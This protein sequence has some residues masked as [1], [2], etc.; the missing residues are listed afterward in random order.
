MRYGWSSVDAKSLWDIWCDP[1]IVSPVQRKTLDGAEPFDE[2]EEFILFASHYFLLIACTSSSMVSKGGAACLIDDAGDGVPNSTLKGVLYSGIRPC[3]LPPGL[4]IQRF[5]SAFYS[6]GV[7]GIHGGL[8]RQG[9]SNT[10][11]LFSV[12]TPSS[13]K[14]TAGC[15]IVS[16]DSGLIL[17][18]AIESRMC[19]AI[20]TSR[21]GTCLLIG[22]RVSP[23]RP[24]MDCWYFNGKWRQV[25]DLPVPLYRQCATWIESAPGIST[26]LAVLVF[27]GKTISN[28]VSG[29]WLLWRDSIGWST[30]ECKGDPIPPTFGATMASIDM[31]SG[32]LIG[33]MTA[34]SILQPNVWKWTISESET[35]QPLIFTAK[36]EFPGSDALQTFTRMGAHFVRSHLGLFLVGGVG[37]GPLGEEIDIVRLEPPRSSVGGWSVFSVI[38]RNQAL[39]TLLVGHSVLPFEESLLIIG[40][41]AVCFSFGCIWNDPLIP[42]D[43]GSR[44]GPPK[45]QILGK[46]TTSL[47]EPRMSTG[48][49]DLYV[50]KTPTIKRLIA[51]E[52]C[53]KILNPKQTENAASTSSNGMP[54]TDSDVPSLNKIIL[55]QTI[56][57]ASRF[58]QILEDGKPTIIGGLKLSTCV[59]QWTLETLKC[60][61]GAERQI[62][63]H[64][65]N[66]RQMDFLQKN[67]VYRQKSVATFFAD[68]SQGAQQYLR[69][70]S[71]EKP[72]DKAA[73]L[74]SDFPELAADFSL[75]AELEFVKENQHS[76]V[77]RISGP[78]NMWLH[79]DVRFSIL[80]R[81]K[82]TDIGDGKC[83]VPDHR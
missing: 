67:F 45:L 82:L 16:D 55:R 37:N 48:E 2:W 13:L 15:A 53:S 80:V 8:G 4:H 77:L 7:V 66:D 61:I 59:D 78:V 9:R 10:T 28:E 52:V 64:E 40:G 74:E 58:I 63:V 69:S 25:Q 51:C 56:A 39:R 26:P 35:G 60:K 6:Q 42:L 54:I 46:M 12:S 81:M 49:A 20:V 73:H 62:I 72:S 44:K 19:H 43:L 22:G 70:L 1:E 34:D 57:D 76:S 27:G 79:Y 65:A 14:A 17:P 33:G 75:P 32:V 29:R 50:Q 30:I 41:G 18:L 24:L 3:D 31:N 23:D 38:C 47:L 71:E 36:F 83:A 68:I 5:G 11:D 21:L